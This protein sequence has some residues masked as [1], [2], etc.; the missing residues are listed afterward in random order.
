MALFKQK[1]LYI[2]V[3]A[4]LLVLV[5]FGVAMMGSVLGAKP[6][7]L[8]VALVVEDQVVTLPD[9]SSLNVGAMVKEKLLALPGLPLAWEI[10]GTE[11]EAR[12][13]LDE[14]KYYGA[15][16]LPA[17]LSA[18]LA[19][20]TTGE[21][22]PATVKILANEG[23]SAQGATAVKQLL[24]Q[25]S[26]M[27][28]AELTQKLLGQLGERSEAI[29][30]TGAKAI[31]T[32]FA[33]QEETV[34]P[35]G[36]NN[37]SGN[38]PGMLTQL[39]WIGS[40]VV[41]IFLFL[42]S[43]KAAAVGERRVTLALLQAVVG[44]ALVV[45]VSGFLVWMSSSWYGMELAD[46]MGTW[47]VLMLALAAFF[48]LQSALLNWI[49]FAAM[50][51]LVLLM[52]FSMPVVNMAQ[53]FLPQATQDWLYAWTPF[54]FVSSGL[55]EA[56]YFSDVGASASNLAVLWWIVG[57]GLVLLVVSGL[58]KPKAKPAEASAT[59]A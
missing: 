21:P 49:G 45:G 44:L 36:A 39:S 22:K 25:V 15:F 56:M 8:P 35:V 41:A 17:D 46:A 42:A 33:I 50:P 9:G 47:L 6:K 54:R 28:S 10:V 53:E 43:L 31:M 11:A 37:A 55:R 4:S 32:P 14:Q 59:A 3:V 5:I 18:G 16:V 26:R 57:V 7:N 1:M 38:A 58:R 19:S 23:M 24:G 12:Q 51:I 52:F 34:H 29:P 48:M 20:L 40:M 27:F 2:G 30:A 13:W